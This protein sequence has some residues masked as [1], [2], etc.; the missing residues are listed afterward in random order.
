MTDTT[1]LSGEFDS[2]IW[3]KEWLKTI[4]EHPGIPTDEGTMI[5]WFANAIMAGFDKA[6]KDDAIVFDAIMS[7]LGVPQLS[8]P[9]PVANAYRM[10]ERRSTQID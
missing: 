3:A 6:K 9:V 8:Y 10:A 7:E 4:A 2:R 5:G 1:N